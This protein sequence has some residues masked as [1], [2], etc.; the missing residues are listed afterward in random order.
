MVTGRGAARPQACWGA[1][2]PLNGSA[3]LTG[4]DRARS[5][6]SCLGTSGVADSVVWQITLNTGASDSVGEYPTEPG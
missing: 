2:P 1:L 5:R 6:T 3:E 4:S